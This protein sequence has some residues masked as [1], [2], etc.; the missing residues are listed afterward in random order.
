MVRRARFEGR[1][2]NLFRGVASPKPAEQSKP[3][4]DDCDAAD[5]GQPIHDIGV[6]VDDRQRL[7]EL[8]EAAERR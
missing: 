8:D 2:S 7:Q 4:A 5:I 1:P 3:D 6:P